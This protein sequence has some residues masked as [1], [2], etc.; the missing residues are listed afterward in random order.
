[1]FRIIIKQNRTWHYSNKESGNLRIRESGNRGIRERQ[2]L[3]TKEKSKDAKFTRNYT[4]RFP[5]EVLLLL[6]LLLLVAR[7]RRNR[8]LIMLDMLPAIISSPLVLAVI[9]VV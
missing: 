5:D 2:R 6:L 4:S 3:I 9:V 8:K 1:M 7:N